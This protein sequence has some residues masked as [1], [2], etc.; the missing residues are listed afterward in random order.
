[1]EIC[2]IGCGGIT[3]C[4]LPPLCKFLEYN[5]ENSIIYLVD[6]DIFEEKNKNRQNFKNLGNKAKIITEEQ[7]FENI[8]FYHYPEYLTKNNIRKI[9]KEKSIIFGCV[10]NH[11]TRKLI[12]KRC[13]EL[14]DIIFISGGNELIDGSVQVHWKKNKEDLTLPICNKYHPE[15]ENPKDFN[16]GDKEKSCNHKIQEGIT[17]LV[18]TNNII[19]AIM[20]NVFYGFLQNIIDYDE[21]YVDIL[22]NSTR[23]VKRN[24]SY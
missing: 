10:D 16:P 13:E 22:K 21:I 23:K 9:I 6:G 18:I 2:I 11:A 19:A 14:N 3:S 7:N 20:L 15:I 24:V 4:L 8:I 17:Q 5:F 12:S 1:M